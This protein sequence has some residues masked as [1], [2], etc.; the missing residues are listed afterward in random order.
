MALDK[1]KIDDMTLA[2]T[3]T[4]ATMSKELF[5]KYFGAKK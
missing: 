1:N 4:G 2:L 3:Q 5:F